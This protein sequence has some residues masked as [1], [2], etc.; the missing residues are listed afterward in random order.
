MMNTASSKYLDH[1]SLIVNHGSI[2][3][4][5]GL[6]FK[7]V[8]GATYTVP[9][10][11]PVINVTGRRLGYRFAAAE[12]YWILSGKNQLADISPFGKMAPYSDDGLFMAGAYGPKVVDQLGY[13]C[14][15][16]AD[17]SGSRQAVLNIWRERPGPSKDIPCTLSMQFMI[18]SGKI[19]CF[20]TMR[21]SDAV[22]G[23]PYDTIFFSLCSAF[24][25]SI[26]RAH[27]HCAHD[28]EL[29]NLS[30]FMGS[31]HV[32]DRDLFLVSNILSLWDPVQPNLNFNKMSGFSPRTFLDLLDSWSV[33]EDGS[34]I[35]EM[36]G[37][38]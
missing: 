15:T 31:S 38:N 32:Y 16:L 9:M 19:H 3:T 18:R 20:T 21:S 4:A 28:V 6:S 7:E 10:S 8:M 34:G 12:P 27:H 17:D 13:V 22:M 23:L 33:D 14:K 29:G 37:L 26:L 1:L 2:E 11:N 36:E 25:L 30:V 24:I 5:R 35:L